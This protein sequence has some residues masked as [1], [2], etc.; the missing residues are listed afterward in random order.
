M[1]QTTSGAQVVLD[2][3]SDASR[4]AR[5]VAAGTFVQNTAVRDANLI[6]V[7]LDTA[8]TNGPPNLAANALVNAAAG[9]YTAIQNVNR[10]NTLRTAAALAR[11]RQR[12]GNAR[13]GFVGD[14]YTRGQGSSL[15]LN[16]LFINAF[17][18]QIAE[19]LPANLNPQW[20]SVFGTGTSSATSLFTNDS[21]MAQTGA[22]GWT[23]AGLSVVGGLALV[24]SGPAGV[25][26]FT[27]MTPTTKCDIW[28]P[29]NVSGSFSWQIDGGAATTINQVGSKS[30]IKTTIGGGAAASHVYSFNWVSGGPNIF[31]LHAYDDTNSRLDLLNFGRGGAASSYYA[32]A[33]DPIWSALP[34]LVD[35]ACDTYFVGLMC[36]DWWVAAQNIPVPQYT[37]NMQTIIT[38]LKAV[39]DV[40]LYSEITQ[41]TATVA[42]QAKQQSYVEAA[43]GL[44][45]TNNVPFIDV[46]TQF[47]NY[48]LANGY[49]LMSDTFHPS[50]AGNSL[51]T[52]LFLN[53]VNSL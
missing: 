41:D 5:G 9:T 31:G 48:T 18:K 2:F 37:I 42:S 52:S 36:N 19:R 25:M 13:F 49:G 10:V 20:Q 24:G 27:P 38:A 35:Y 33:V 40:V 26:T 14:S 11:V 30:V 53:F 28:Y 22:G 12:V 21:R 29:Q 44:A 34:L 51:S 1:S 3:N 46:W 45:V 47:Q 23:G 39:G 8:N 6:S 15:T 32:N 50:A 17:P 7:G 4:G 16:Q 43:R